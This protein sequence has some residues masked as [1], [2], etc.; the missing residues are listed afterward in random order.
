MVIPY[1][2]FR[3]KQLI[4]VGLKINGQSERH[5]DVILN[6]VDFELQSSNSLHSIVPINGI[7]VLSY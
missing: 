3:W 2:H 6:G 1:L 7:F 4:T 5:I